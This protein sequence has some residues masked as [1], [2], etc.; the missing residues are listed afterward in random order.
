MNLVEDK[1]V[2]FAFV[3]I[4]KSIKALAADDLFFEAFAEAG[5]LF[6]PD[7]DI[8]LVHATH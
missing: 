2:E 8:D 6:G 1:L 3:D 5:S 4:T 7:K